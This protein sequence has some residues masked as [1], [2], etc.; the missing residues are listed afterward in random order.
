MSGKRLL[1]YG[2]EEILG[3]PDVQELYELYR[4]YAHSADYEFKF[5][6]PNEFA[7]NLTRGAIKIAM[8]GPEDEMCEDVKFRVGDFVRHTGA[9]GLATQNGE[10]IINHA[11]LVRMES[12]ESLESAD[13]D[14]QMLDRLCRLVKVRWCDADGN[15]ICIG[16][17]S[18]EQIEK[19]GGAILESLRKTHA[20]IL[21]HE[22]ASKELASKHVSTRQYKLWRLLSPMEER[23]L[24]E[25]ETV[26]H[27]ENRKPYFLDYDVEQNKHLNTLVEA[28]LKKHG[29]LPSNVTRW[30]DPAVPSTDVL[31][32]RAKQVVQGTAQGSLALNARRAS[33][34]SK[35]MLYWL[36]ENRIP[37]GNLSTIAGDPDEGKSLITLS[38]AAYVSRGKKLYGNTEDGQPAEVLILSAEDDPETTLR[39]RLEAAGADLYRIHLLESIILKDGQGRQS[40]RLAQLDSD[41]AM[42]GTYL[43]LYPQIKLVVIDPIS[44]F[45][46]SASMNKEQEVRRVLQPLAKR[47]RESGLAVVMVAHFNKNSDTRAAM[48]RVG[49]AKAI[50]GMG[51]AAWTCV[52]EPEKETKEGEPTPLHDSDRRLFL[53]LKNNMAPSKIGGLVYTIKTAPVEVAA[54]DGS[55]VTVDVPYIVWLGPTEHTAQGV[56]IGDRNGSPKPT[57]ADSV[58]DW[59]HGHL[60]AAGGYA[61]AESV[62][63]A[64]TASGYSGKGTVQRARERLGVKVVWVGRSSYWV[65]KGS[66]LPTTFTSPSEPGAEP[67]TAA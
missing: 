35:K 58:K 12:D 11:Y 3:A 22:E 67:G 52:R 66:K 13:W 33:T 32:P 61:S 21:E 27:L 63:E 6:G 14:A 64:A 31:K 19:I 24:R 30:D 1:L 17:H 45:L 51:R 29:K 41:I 4:Q 54:K 2:T 40:E 20:R 26:E 15:T 10:V 46:G 59:L 23:L 16:W 8:A 36:W 48:D 56:V 38:I 42:I 57:K 62:M 50:V 18:P 28:H 34:F 43:D 25:G 9:N 39:P 49:G 53:K 37:Y 65:L 7:E 60:T 55:P 44:S 47:A 5:L